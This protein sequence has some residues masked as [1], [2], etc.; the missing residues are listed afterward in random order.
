MDTYNLDRKSTTAD[1]TK[2]LIDWLNTYDSPKHRGTIMGG[3]FK[4]QHRTLEGTAVNFL[5]AAIVAIADDDLIDCRNEQA[6]G[7]ARKVKD[8]VEQDGY[9]MLI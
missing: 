8:I 9:Q 5:L 6:I 2:F 1:V 3:I 4:E 7:L